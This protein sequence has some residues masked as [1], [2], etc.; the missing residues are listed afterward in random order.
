ML[1]KDVTIAAYNVEL[2]FD[3]TCDSGN[4]SSTSFEQVPSESAFRAKAKAIAEGIKRTNADVVML[5]EVES[6]ASLDAVK[7]ELP[8]FRESRVA[9]TGSGGNINVA[10]LAKDPISNTARHRGTRFQTS[11][12]RT[13]RF[14]REFFEVEMNR[15]GTKYTV[16]VGHFKAKRDD[17]PALRLAEATRARQIVLERAK[18]FPTR[19]IVMGGDLNDGPGSPPINML[20]SNDAQGQLVRVLGVDVPAE[21][22]YTWFG[23]SFRSKL[24]HLFVPKP[25]ADRYAMGSAKVVKDGAT[26]GLG[27]S[28]HGA[29]V[30]RFTLP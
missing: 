12:G 24:D 7:A 16:F 27:G 15:N 11:D 30:A 26:R 19:L 25:I 14:V 17:D 4:C 20:E 21:E 23:G 5:E 3:T 28:D 6:Q 10:I 2:F 18:A 13:E 8:G 9:D 29:V 22:Q 1:G